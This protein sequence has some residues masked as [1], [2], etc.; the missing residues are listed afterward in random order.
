MLHIRSHVLSVLAIAILTSSAVASGAISEVRFQNG[1]AAQAN[2]PV[3][4]GQVF[5]VGD[6]RRSDVLV[7]KLGGATVPLQVDVKATHADGSV[8]HA[9]ISAVLPKLA[10]GATGTMTLDTGG[11][12]PAG[13]STPARLLATGFTASASATIG[14][15]RYGA[16][17][18]QLLRAGAK[19]TWLSGA[20]ANEW[21][22]SAPLATAAGVAHPHLAARFAIRYYPVVKK[23]RVDV[24]IENAWAYEPGP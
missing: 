19:A 9:V 10:A 2:I 13:S 8:R 3:T 1:G 6:L 12:V 4:F 16:S 22:V 21:H 7:G 11:A 15:V 23:A 24:T 5:A 14:G 18:D 17:A 20:V